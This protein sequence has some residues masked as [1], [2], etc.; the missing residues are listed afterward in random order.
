MRDSLMPGLEGVDQ[1]PGHL[2]AQISLHF[3]FSLW[4]YINTLRTG[5]FSSMYHKSLIQ[6]KVKFFFKI[7]PGGPNYVRFM[8][9]VIKC[10]KTKRELKGN[11]ASP[12]HNVLRTLCMLRR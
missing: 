9:R 1:Y 12:V 4:G 2:K 3:I 10:V 11:F 7:Q 8:Y 5:I 6:S